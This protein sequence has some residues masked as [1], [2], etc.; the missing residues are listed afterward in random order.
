MFIVAGAGGRGRTE[1]P[2]RIAPVAAGP[3]ILPRPVPGRAPQVLIPTDDHRVALSPEM[4]RFVEARAGDAVFHTDRGT[5][6]L[7]LSLARIEQTLA[8]WGFLRT[9]R[10][11]LINLGRVQA[12][13]PWSRTAHSLLLDDGQ[14]THVPVA[15]S[16]LAA[17]RGSVIWIPHSGGPRSG[18][19]IEGKGG[20][21]GRRQPRV[22]PGDRR[23][24][25]R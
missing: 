3:D 16:R 18:P 15:K 8:P 13:I 20:D 10:A 19:R 17:F 5:F 4:I 11:Y 2:A 9:H 1:G 21:R 14:E 23:R 12:L 7:R 6:R 22:G 25:G 24:A